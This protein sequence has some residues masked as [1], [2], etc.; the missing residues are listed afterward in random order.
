MVRSCGK[1]P[2]V[3]QFCLFLDEQYVLKCKG[4]LCNSTLSDTAKNPALLPPKHWF[5]RLLIIDTHNQ[6][7]HGG[8]NITL[9]VLRE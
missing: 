8:I 3:H 1:P 5:V 7:K 2:Y 9:T 6:V 4:R